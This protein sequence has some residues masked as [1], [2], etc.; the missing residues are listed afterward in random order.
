VDVTLAA[1]GPYR[2]EVSANPPTGSAL[3]DLSIS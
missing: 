2:L 1:S 3:V